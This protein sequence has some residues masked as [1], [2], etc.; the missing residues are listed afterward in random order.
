[1][2]CLLKVMQGKPGEISCEVVCTLCLKKV[3]TLE[4]SATLS[5][6]NRFSKFLHCWNMYETCYKPHTILPT[7]P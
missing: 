3:P 7:S 5:N 2:E 4:L 6:L 1:M